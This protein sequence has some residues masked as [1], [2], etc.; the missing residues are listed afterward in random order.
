MFE[1]YE[2]TTKYRIN[3]L[4]VQLKIRLPDESPL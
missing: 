2:Q 3:G 4:F 1:K